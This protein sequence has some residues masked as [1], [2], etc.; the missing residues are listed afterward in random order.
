MYR[1]LVIKIQDV[2]RTR[3][4][5]VNSQGN[6]LP[7]KNI[8][9]A[10]TLQNGE[11]VT[12]LFQSPMATQEASCS[13]A[14]CFA[15]KH[16]LHNTLMSLLMLPTSPGLDDLWHTVKEVNPYWRADWDGTFSVSAFIFLGLNLFLIALGVSVLWKHQRLTGLFPMVAFVI[17]D[18]ANSVARTSG[19][20]YIVPMDWILAIY[21]MAGILF[22][23]VELARVTNLKQVSLSEAESPIEQ[24]AVPPRFWRKVIPIVVVLFVAGSLVP[25]S[26]LFH[27]PRYAGFDIPK[28]LREQATQIKEAGLDPEQVNA[29]LKTPG[30]EAL[31]G[32]TLYPRSYKMGQGE[33]SFYFY[34]YTIMD[35]PRTGFFLIG[36]HGKDSILL[37]GGVP[38]YLPHAADAL[39][40]GCREQNYVD[41]LAVI[42]LDESGAVYTRSPMPELAC[43]MKQPVCDN[44]SK[45]Q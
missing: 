31:V 32:R 36:P 43:P 13:S 3:Y 26:E 2:I 27:S 7:E 19:G 8:P 45:C 21:F 38:R 40:I 34:P 28:T 18:L 16:I 6:L 39:V 22:L 5:P 30:A 11:V 15:P 25:L 24:S 10:L 14:A 20:R 41:A 12:S 9:S 37:P 33:V 42:V 29:F 23:F 1:S 4:V 44:N 35:F 17:Y